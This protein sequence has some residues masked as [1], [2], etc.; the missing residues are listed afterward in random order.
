MRVGVTGHRSLAD[1]TVVTADVERVLDDLVAGTPG[2][3]EVWSSLAEGADRVVATVVLDRPGGTLVA[4][5]PLAPGDYRDDFA[6]AASRDEFDRLLEHASRVEVTGPDASGT[7]ESA[8][9]RAGLVI[10]ERC[11]VLLALWD[12]AP[13]RGRGGTADIV[14]EARTRGRDT[15]VVPVIRS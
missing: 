3:I 15:V 11:D 9:E 12:G 4:V 2:H 1:T 6:G 7:R 13:S 5:L 14:T 8:Y 10:V